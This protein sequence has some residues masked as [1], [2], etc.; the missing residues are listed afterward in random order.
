NSVNLARN[1]RSALVAAA[2]VA[3]DTALVHV[4]ADT[5]KTLRDTLAR[6]PKG[7]DKR[8][9]TTIRYDI[10]A[11]GRAL[12]KA[13]TDGRI[14]TNPVR[15]YLAKAENRIPLVI[16]EPD[17]PP[18]IKFGVITPTLSH[19]AGRAFEMAV[20]AGLSYPEAVCMRPEFIDPPAGTLVVGLH[21]KS[22]NTVGPPKDLEPRT[23]RGLD[24]AWLE[25]LLAAPRYPDDDGYLLQAVGRCGLLGRRSMRER[26]AEEINA[27][28][29]RAGMLSMQTGLPY[30]GKDLKAA[31][32]AEQLALRPHQLLTVQAMVGASN[33]AHFT[34]KFASFM[35]DADSHEQMEGTLETLDK[36]GAF[37]PGGDRL[38]AILDA[39]EAIGGAGA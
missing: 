33:T 15:A 22:D 3:P 21:W 2:R 34:R 13:V 28:Q 6:P 30:C 29:R 25:W 24:R 17:V 18:E 10:H 16:R 37:K 20:K 39:W 9:E 1:D 26:V 8:S 36:L 12:D 35:N 5:I 14:P 38:Q 11:V 31:Y 23:V 19:Y 7:V 4:T 27:A 32:A